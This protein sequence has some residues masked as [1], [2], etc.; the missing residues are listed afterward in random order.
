MAEQPTPPEQR[1]SPTPLPPPPTPPQIRIPVCR[2]WSIA[3]ARHGGVQRSMQIQELFARAG[4]ELVPAG[5]GL[6]AAGPGDWWRGAR[7]WAGMR[8]LTRFTRNGAV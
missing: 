8:G 5:D 1:P 6:A 4:V 7:T 3:E 2:P